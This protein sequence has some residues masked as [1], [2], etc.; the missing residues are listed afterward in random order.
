MYTSYIVKRTQ[1]YL[2]ERQADALARRARAHGQTASHVIREAVDRYLAEPDDESERLDRF[3]AALD[4]SFGVAP[5]LVPGD[6]YVRELRATDRR[7]DERL[8]RRWRG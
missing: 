1:I 8:E 6:E 7:R 2:E 3:R 5:Y 4:E